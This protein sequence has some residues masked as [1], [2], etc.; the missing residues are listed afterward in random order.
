LEIVKLLITAG[1]TL[2]W[3][4]ENSGGAELLIT[5]CTLGH[6]TIVDYLLE[7]FDA[8][9]ISEPD[10]KKP[11]LRALS[12]AFISACSH[13]YLNIVKSLLSRDCDTE[14]RDKTCITPIIAAARGGHSKVISELLEAG[15]SVDS[16]SPD[17][18]TLLHYIVESGNY[19]LTQR[20]INL[21]AKISART[22]EGKIDN[23]LF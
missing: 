14:C 3:A 7:C 18:W 23:E 5:A 2:N 21:G 1:A 10:D 17:G 15:A 4:D 9:L 20:V 12:M 22:Y 8:A 16:V 11:D 13:G 6:T 19:H